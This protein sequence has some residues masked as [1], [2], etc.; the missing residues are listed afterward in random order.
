MVGTIRGTV[1]PLG[2]LA[3][4]KLRRARRMT[5]CKLDPIWKSGHKSRTEVYKWLSKKL[6]IPFDRCHIGTF[7]TKMCCIVMTMCD[8]YR[9][10]NNIENKE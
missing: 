9:R 7:D 2:T 8:R 5:H 6:N 10:L 3:D 1:I 4:S